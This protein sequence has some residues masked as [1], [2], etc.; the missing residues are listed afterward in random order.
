MTTVGYL[1]GEVRT[2]QFT[3]VTNREIAPPRLEYIVVRVQE[4]NRKIDVLAQ[5]TGLTVNSRLLD[6]SLSYTEV[7]SILNRLKSSPPI[8][9]GTAQVLGYLDG[10]SVQFPR[11]AATPGAEVSLAP[12]E[13]L[14]KFFSHNVQS[15]IE[16]GTLI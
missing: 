15:G 11:H 9:E 6:R 8:V 5:V 12:D 14:R 13:L 2:D 10:N 1:V 3:F 16:L 4:P 7:E